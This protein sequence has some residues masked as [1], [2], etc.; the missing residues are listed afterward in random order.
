M[1]EYLFRGKAKCSIRELNEIGFEHHN[2]W[3]YGTY[4]DGYIINGVAES[5][6]EYIVIENWCPVHKMS[7]GQYIGA[8]DKNGKK[9][10]EN[11]IAE[12]N[13]YSYRQPECLALFLVVYNGIGFEFSYRKGKMYYNPYAEKVE[14]VGNKFDNPEMLEEWHE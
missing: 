10:F 11:D 1:R 5:T 4:V 9:I 14:I 7:V 6:D 3:V 12:I 13:Y 8:K 2:G